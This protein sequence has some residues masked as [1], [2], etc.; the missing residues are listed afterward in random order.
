MVY[1]LIREY[2]VAWFYLF[3]QGT[4][5]SCS[6][7]MGTALFFQSPNIRPE[8]HLGRKYGVVFAVSGDDRYLNP[9]IT[10]S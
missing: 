9:L 3:P 7:D 1:K 5:R 2:E 6:Q 8:I 10:H 4:N